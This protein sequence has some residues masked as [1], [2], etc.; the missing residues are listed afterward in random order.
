[1]DKGVF[2]LSLDTELAWGCCSDERKIQRNRRY[3]MQTRENINSLLNLL[4][5][6]SI[7]AT[8]NIVGHLFLSSCSPINNVVH[9]EIIRPR[10]SW[11][12]GDWFKLD[13]CSNIESAPIWY[14]ADIVDS[15]RS[16][17]VPQEIGCH[18]FSHIIVDDTGC[19]QECLDS[20]LKVC[21]DLAR[22]LNIQLKS[23]V[24]PRN[25]EF[26]TN[27]LADN[28]FNAYRGREPHWHSR[29]PEI[30]QKIAYFVE[31]LLFFVSPP[32]GIP[33]KRE[34][35]DIKGSY[36][37]GHCDHMAKLLP[38][39]FR[40]VK[41]KR[42]IDKAAAEQKVFHLWFHPFNLAS[43]PQGL[44]KGLDSLFSYVECMRD[45]GKMENLTMGALANKL[46]VQNGQ[47]SCIGKEIPV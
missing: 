1:M 38:I 27:V 7:S 20:E 24:F 26:F 33:Q 19:R 13:P 3:F 10:Y 41:V 39:S 32:V 2:V 6:H 5:R 36:F 45:E 42:G 9:P 11:F 43:N 21:Q 4:E 22:G 34:C 16:C 47:A 25:R 30:V 12:S 46:E 14:G 18:T 29:C 44:L 31:S 35:W 40:V 17:K 15:I 37:Y 23:F 28:G 8:W